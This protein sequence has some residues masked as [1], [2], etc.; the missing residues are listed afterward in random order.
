MYSLLGAEE[1][2]RNC[3][4]RL[5]ANP[6]SLAANLTMFNLAKINGEYNRALGYI[7]K[8]LQVAGPD[9][10][11]RLDYTTKKV[12]VL[13]LAYEKTSDNNYLTSAIAEYESLLAKM[14][15]NMSALNNLAYMLAKNNERLA[16][17]LTFARRALDARPN[18]PSFLDTY[19]YLLHKNGK[20]SE[21]AEFLQAALQQYEQ[22]NIPVPA[23][24][25]EHLR[26][27][28]EELGNSSQLRR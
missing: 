24:V 14:P 9:S 25:Y 28:K 16:E 8:C 17:A 13:H 6:D 18:N 3:E 21:A 19:A 23:E 4:E 27:I 10:S 1:A 11:A 22:N 20:N 2:L 7:D 5:R 12:G 26:L 15:N